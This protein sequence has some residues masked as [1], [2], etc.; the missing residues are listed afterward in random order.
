M[1]KYAL[2]LA[3]LITMGRAFPLEYQLKKIDM[4]NEG[5][6]TAY[7][8]F[9]YKSITADEPFKQI[10]ADYFKEKGLGE[11]GFESAKLDNDTIIIKWD[12]NQ[13]PKRAYDNPWCYYLLNEIGMGGGN[14]NQSVNGFDL[15]KNSALGAKKHRSFSWLNPDGIF[16]N[17]HFSLEFTYNEQG[18]VEKCD[19]FFQHMEGTVEMEG[20]SFNR[21]KMSD[22]DGK[23]FSV[24]N[25]PD[26]IEFKYYLDIWKHHIL[27][28]PQ[29]LRTQTLEPQITEDSIS[30]STD[31]RDVTLNWEVKSPL[32][33]PTCTIEV[34]GELQETKNG[35][36][37][38]ETDDIYDF[39]HTFK[40]PHYGDTVS[41]TITPSL[42]AGIEG[43]PVSK[44]VTTEALTFKT[45]VTNELDIESK[46]EGYHHVHVEMNGYKEPKAFLYA[47]TGE[48]PIEGQQDSG[49]W[50]FDTSYRINGLTRSLSIQDGE[51]K[52][53]L[54]EPFQTL[55]DRSMVTCDIATS[56]TAEERAHL[57]ITFSGYPH[58]QSHK[59]KCLLRWENQDIDLTNSATY[60]NG[61]WIFQH[62]SDPLDYNTPY[63]YTLHLTTVDTESFVETFTTTTPSSIMLPNILEIVDSTMESSVDDKDITLSWQ[64][65]NTH[66]GETLCDIYLDGEKIN[67]IQAIPGFNPYIFDFE[68]KQAANY[69]CKKHTYI[70]KPHTTDA[71][72]KP[73]EGTIRTLPMRTALLLNDFNVNVDLT[74]LQAHFDIEIADHRKDTLD[75]PTCLLTWNGHDKS[76]SP[77]PY[78]A[79]TW[80]FSHLSEPLQAGQPYS[81]A[82]TIQDQ[83][84]KDPPVLKRGEMLIPNQPQIVFPYIDI[85]YD[86]QG[87][88]CSIRPDTL[89]K[90]SPLLGL[91]I[92]VDG[93]PL[94]Q[95]QDGSYTSSTPIPYT[96]GTCLF[97]IEGQATGSSPIQVVCRIKQPDSPQHLVVE[98]VP[99]TNGDLIVNH[100]I[101]GAS[102]SLTLS[103]RS[104]SIDLK[105]LVGIEE[106]TWTT[107]GSDLQNYHLYSLQW[108]LQDANNLPLA[109]ITTTPWV[110]P[111]LERAQPPKDYTFTP[112]RFGGGLITIDPSLTY[113]SGGVI[114]HS[115]HA[116]GLTFE[117]QS[118][119]VFLVG[120]MEADRLYDVTIMAID[121][122]NPHSETASKTITIM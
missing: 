32:G 28:C 115:L 55:P 9:H 78:N 44:N 102:E 54:S 73:V 121:A 51:E 86:T 6:A 37:R 100:D 52:D 19:L 99:D 42:F 63:E 114:Q 48:S 76:L 88:N 74:T 5:E 27:F 68:Y 17:N 40:T 71:N 25:F 96:E 1:K 22:L 60:E 65:K 23:K 70:I 8:E 49:K 11:D 3:M 90:T 12:V 13:L 105:K 45:E 46:K 119:H 122:S 39:E 7:I 14:A 84:K 30:R 66:L 101:E 120:G 35:T 38:D 112:Y 36:L 77:G 33:Q 111:P 103:T 81:Y 21:Q 53:M 93:I 98:L 69:S 94:N 79:G 58:A 118:P 117:E 59:P 75:L 20:T 83:E 72:E 61:S 64:V 15:R 85:T 29:L 50:T 18:Q 107:K 89:P 16:T 56:Y 87:V 43:D 31:G 97:N 108:E 113:P 92:S 80:T 41:Y 26:G 82:F 109:R 4:N 91:N 10:H 62:T 47:N 34:V 95:Q 110:L 57:A 116:E 104:Q 2:L 67:T 106:A 24:T